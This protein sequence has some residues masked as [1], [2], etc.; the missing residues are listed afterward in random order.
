MNKGIINIKGKEYATVA[1]RVAEFRK[2][3]EGYAI[4]T[5]I[6]ERTDTFIL[7]ETT[8]TDTNKN[9]VANGHAYEERSSSYINK[10]SYIENCETS[11]I[12]RALACFGLCGEEFGVNFASAEE[13]AK[14][15]EKQTDAKNKESKDSEIIKAMD[16]AADVKR[17]N[18]YLLPVEISDGYTITQEDKEKNKELLFEEVSP[19]TF[20]KINF[21]C[22]ALNLYRVRAKNGK[23]FYSRQYLHVLAGN[24]TNTVLAE[25]AKKALELTKKG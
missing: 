2:K 1:Y 6:V 3:Y 24:D 9:M 21:L 4:I 15:I 13:V 12:G 17:N 19:T 5:K 23:W 18:A 16:E 10:T 25:K 8:I 7:M 11:A 20:G 22:M 14:A